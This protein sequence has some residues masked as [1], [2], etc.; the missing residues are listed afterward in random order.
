MLWTASAIFHPHLAQKEPCEGMPKA[1]CL[2]GGTA[3]KVTSFLPSL[4]PKSKST[5]MEFEGTGHI[6]GWQV[7]LSGL[8]RAL[9]FSLISGWSYILCTDLKIVDLCHQG[10][11][12][13]IHASQ[14]SPKQEIQPFFLVTSARVIKQ[15]QSA[16]GFF[17]WGE[18]LSPH[19]SCM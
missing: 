13:R 8:L 7:S 9:S 19:F 16:R 11:P 18:A 15:G 1:L 5:P 12:S 4:H 17:T 6:K 2:A 3:S 10:R 14:Q